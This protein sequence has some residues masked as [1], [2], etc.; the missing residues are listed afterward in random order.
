MS[1]KP[2]RRSIAKLMIR[3]A[4]YAGHVQ[5]CKKNASGRYDL[6]IETHAQ[7]FDL[8]WLIGLASL[9]DTRKLTVETLGTVHE[10]DVENHIHIRDAHVGVTDGKK[11]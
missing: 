1:R 7:E 4:G 8:E 2:T 9:F 10:Y 6:T 11:S 3:K 5:S